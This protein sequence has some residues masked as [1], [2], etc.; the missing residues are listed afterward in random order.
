MTRKKLT[1][2][3]NVNFY[4]HKRPEQISEIKICFEYGGGCLVLN[5][6]KIYHKNQRGAITERIDLAGDYHV[7]FRDNEIVLNKDGKE[8]KYHSLNCN[9]A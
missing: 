8:C 5:V 9:L 7:T 1:K 6:L 3:G 4:I 2:G